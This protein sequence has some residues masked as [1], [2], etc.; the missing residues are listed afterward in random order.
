MLP[1]CCGGGKLDIH[2]GSEHDYIGD[3]RYFTTLFWKTTGMFFIFF[4]SHY[5]S[6][7]FA[8]LHASEI[9]VLQCGVTNHD[10]KKKAHWNEMHYWDLE[11][12][13]SLKKFDY[14]I[15][16]Q[17]CNFSDKIYMLVNATSIFLTKI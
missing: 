3:T 12:R 9:N 8:W 11:D 16:W 17:N 13:N 5:F 10:S 6:P 7:D 15:I 4:A 14:L 1:E 2:H